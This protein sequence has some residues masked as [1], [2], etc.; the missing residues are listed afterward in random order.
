MT[1]TAATNRSSTDSSNAAAADDSGE[2]VA[3]QPSPGGRR[4]KMLSF[5]PNADFFVVDSTAPTTPKSTNGGGNSRV[6]QSS[7]ERGRRTG[8]A[9]NQSLMGPI[10]PRKK[11]LSMPLCSAASNDFF[12]GTADINSRPIMEETVAEDGSLVSASSQLMQQQAAARGSHVPHRTR[13]NTAPVSGRA[14]FQVDGGV[15]HGDKHPSTARRSREKTNSFMAGLLARRAVAMDLLPA[16]DA[17]LG[18]YEFFRPQAAPVGLEHYGEETKE[19][20]GEDLETGVTGEGEAELLPQD[21]G[22]VAAGKKKKLFKPLIFAPRKMMPVAGGGHH[23][24]PHGHGGVAST[25]QVKKDDDKKPTNITVEKDEDVL[26][27]SEAIPLTTGDADVPKK[28]DDFNDNVEDLDENSQDET[29]SLKHEDDSHIIRATKK[30]YFFTGFLFVVMCCLV[31]VVVGWPTH[32]DESDSIFGPVGLACK[33]PC[34]GDVYD[35]DY[36]R[37]RNQ[38]HSG[39][40]IFLTPHIDTT[41]TEDSYLRMAI[42]GVQSNKTKW[43][44]SDDT[45]G[46]ASL[47]GKRVTKEARVTVNWENP[48]EQHVIDVWSNT[49]SQELPPPYYESTTP[50]ESHEAN[51]THD[52]VNDS[53]RARVLSVTGDAITAPDV[54]HHGELT[55]T[56]YASTLSP[57]AEHSVLIAALIMIFVY[58]FILLEVIHRTLVALFGS[59]V[60]LFFL[61]LMHGGHTESIHTIMLHMEW[62]TLVRLLVASKGSFN[63]LMI[64]LCALVALSSAFLDNV[65]TMLLI[66]PVTIDMCGILGVDP[67]PYLIG[68]VLLSNVGGT[69][70]MI[71]DPPNIIIGSSFEEIGTSTCFVILM[72]FLHP[73]HHKDTAW[74]ALLGAFVTIAFTNP[75]DVQDAL[76]NHVEWD[77]LLFFAG[78]FVLVEVCAAMGLLQAI[79]DALASV[80]KSLPEE[81]QL[82]VAITLII[83]VSAITSAFLDNIP[84]TATM[85]PVVRVL[86]DELPHTL[87]ITILAWALSFGACLGGNGTLLGASA[88]IVTAGLSTSKGYGISFLN[89]FYPGMLTMLFTTAIANIYMLIGDNNNDD[90]VKNSLCR[91][92]VLDANQAFI[93]R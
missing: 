32:L 49:G 83:W 12:K 11:V 86:A 39:D 8:Q 29:I 22:E 91:E 21:E 37:G 31:G 25:Q 75:H 56:L 26:H 76:R 72:F 35:Q 4:K 13:Q 64:L 46:P 48:E 69:A 85:I 51:A 40:I 50:G 47:D 63:R 57:L 41:L 80:I 1:K 17:D 18:M 9:G 71:G 6:R 79:G 20:E 42:R 55:F 10:L 16:D 81:S 7:H 24:H 77:T 90:L 19:E 44:S 28:S 30:D 89:F 73:V 87:D 38:F 2:V 82:S 33:T 27:A 61:F 58:I 15:P 54:P 36:F 60:A 84:Y 62:S 43:V 53:H 67:R 68:E 14:F 5:E 3:R 70:T 74:I 45:F 78:L 23:G 34:R 59:F 52:I 92:E 88:N 93:L 66:A 65:T